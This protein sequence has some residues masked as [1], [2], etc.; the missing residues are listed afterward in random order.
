M[1]NSSSTC[2]LSMSSAPSQSTS[3]RS[4]SA[5][6]ASSS[7]QRVEGPAPV[8]MLVSTDVKGTKPPSAQLTPGWNH[9]HPMSQ[10]CHKKSH[11]KC[12][13]KNV[14]E[15]KL[16]LPVHHHPHYVSQ[17]KCSKS[18]TKKETKKSQNRSFGYK[19]YFGYKYIWWKM[20]FLALTKIFRFKGRVS[21]KGQYF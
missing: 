17:K 21:T 16:G 1:T 13:K 18:V 12:H 15:K 4:T 14:T 3:A 19:K 2:R 11:E 20:W 7:L 9:P 5:R 6:S 8:Q 10:K